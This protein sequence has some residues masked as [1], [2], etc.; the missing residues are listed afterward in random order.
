VREALETGLTVAIFALFALGSI[1][2]VGN[3]LYTERHGRDHQLLRWMRNVGLLLVWPL[4]V[5][6]AVL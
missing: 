6:R 1:G 5:L 4:I 2:F 3:G